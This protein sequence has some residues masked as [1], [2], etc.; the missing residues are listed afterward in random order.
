MNFSFLS[1]V[2]Q[3]DVW[4]KEME[5]KKLWNNKH[6]HA[7]RLWR[8]WWWLYVDWKE[9]RTNG[10]RQDKKKYSRRAEINAAE[11]RRNENNERELA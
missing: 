3:Q 6:I 10:I 8:W 7:L 4:V 5:S 2:Q 9:V 1:Y 11:R